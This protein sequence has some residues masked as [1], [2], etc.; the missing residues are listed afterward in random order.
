MGKY[1]KWTKKMVLEAAAQYKTRYEFWTKNRNAYNFANS[2]NWLEESC[3]HMEYTKPTNWTKEM[4]LKE[5]SQY[6]TRWE[7]GTKNQNAYH[8]ARTHHWLDEACSHMESGLR[9]DNDTIYLWRAIGQYFNSEP[10]YKIGMTSKRL[11]TQRIK[12]VAKEQGFKYGII[13]IMETAG[14]ATKIE[15]KLLGLGETPRLTGNGST[16]FRSLNNQELK[17]A[18]FII[19]T[20][21]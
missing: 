7:F 18:L 6:K 11:G 19:K 13:A 8:F 16:E 15:K 17:M 9:S 1:I 10:I 21:A 3:S 4:I 2:H 20:A 12:E 5:A 14:K